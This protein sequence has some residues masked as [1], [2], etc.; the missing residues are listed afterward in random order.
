MYDPEIRPKTRAEKE[1]QPYQIHPVMLTL[2][3]LLFLGITIAAFGI[4]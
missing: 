2:G 1:P 3:F 4:H